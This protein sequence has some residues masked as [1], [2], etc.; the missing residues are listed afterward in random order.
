MTILMI[1]NGALYYTTMHL[2]KGRR[3]GGG[4]EEWGKGER[5]GRLGGGG[6]FFS[7]K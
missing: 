7:I 6:I 1:I 4:E 3:V 2:K 5:N